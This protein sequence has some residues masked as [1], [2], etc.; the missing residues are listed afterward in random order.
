MSIFS[1]LSKKDRKIIFSGENISGDRVPSG[2]EMPDGSILT[3]T[4]EGFNTFRMVCC[5]SGKSRYG[6]A[7]IWRCDTAM[8]GEERLAER[9]I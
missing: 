4:M 5:P 6:A 1:K 7:S 2:I 9:A 3:T 8:S